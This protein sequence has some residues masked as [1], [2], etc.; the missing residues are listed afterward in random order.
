M[1]ELPVRRPDGRRLLHLVPH[2]SI[3]GVELAAEAAA[4]EGGGV[5]RTYF[6]STPVQV[7]RRPCRW[8]TSSSQRSSLS[9][10]AILDALRE[11]RR[12]D[13]D[14]VVFSLWRSVLAFIAVRLVFPR[15]TAVVFLHNTKDKHL[16]SALVARF[17][18]RFADVLW[19]DSAATAVSY[20]A[21]SR[22]ARPISMVL[23][24]TADQVAPRA[25]KPIFASW[26][27]LDVQKRIHL[28]IELIAELKKH[29]QDV[30][31]S[32]IGPDTGTLDFLVAEAERLGVTRE[33]AF[34]GPKDRAGIEEA[35]GQATFY[36]QL[37]SFEGQSLAVAEAMQLGL[38]PVVTP[39]GGIADY[40]QDGVNAIFFSDLEATVARLVDL[41]TKPQQV[42]DLAL[43]ARSRFSSTKSYTQDVLDAFG[44]IIDLPA[45]PQPA[46][47]RGGA[48]QV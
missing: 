12:Q 9:P 32:V 8:I 10:G 24:R 41:L 37:S 47:E 20:R 22:P 13:P 28:A 42:R 5:L 6:L 43:A 39:V 14:V 36:L 44:E 16:L 25:V 21:R 35:A 31:F 2:Y 18:V 48:Q 29:R 45:A 46:V 33:V 4:R 17:M 38:V 26:C 27:R 30:R 23:H 15:K 19:A 34:L 40:C 1:S 11:V 7:E 3:G